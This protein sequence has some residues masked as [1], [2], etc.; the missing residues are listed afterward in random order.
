MSRIKDVLASVYEQDYVTVPMA[1]EE[2]A[3][4]LLEEEA[5]ARIAR[6]KREMQA[7]AKKLDFERAAS[8]RDQIRALEA[9]RLKYA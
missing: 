9:G 3:P 1:A 7:A 8:L 5:S 6:L 4:Y 2:Q